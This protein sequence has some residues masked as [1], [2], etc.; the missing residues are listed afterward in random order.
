MLISTYESLPITHLPS[1][2]VTSVQH[3]ILHLFCI[4][5]AAAVDIWKA[6]LLWQH[7][8]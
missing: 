7:A 4:N 3:P 6:Y 8:W 1:T 5:I 2:R